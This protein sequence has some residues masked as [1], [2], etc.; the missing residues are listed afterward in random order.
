MHYLSLMA[1]VNIRTCI[2]TVHIY[3]TDVYASSSSY[4]AWSPRNFI[5]V[6]SLLDEWIQLFSDWIVT[7]VLDHLIIF[8]LYVSYVYILYMHT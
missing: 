6:V 1:Y 4:S 8:K 7:N 5:P 3:I 2:C